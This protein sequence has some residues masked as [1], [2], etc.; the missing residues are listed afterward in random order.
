MNHRPNFFVTEVYDG[1][2]N[3]T[4]SAGAIS[5]VVDTPY[6]MSFVSTGTAVSSWVNGAVDKAAGD[7]DVGSIT[8]DQAT[9]GALRNGGSTTSDEH[10]G[11]IGEIAIY[12]GAHSTQSRK[13]QEY[14][15][16][17]MWGITLTG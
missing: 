11:Q 16:S 12:T 4:T 2:V 15:L 7:I 3:K 6:I 17:D 5:P 14:R 8:L 10:N 1:S 9:I 13:A